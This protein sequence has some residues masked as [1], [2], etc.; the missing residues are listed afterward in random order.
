MASYFILAVLIAV[1]AAASYNKPNFVKDLPDNMQKSY[2]TIVRN[3]QLTKLQKDEQLQQWAQTNNL[4]DQY[5]A[6]TKKQQDNENFMSKNT[7][8]IISQLSSV[9]AQLEAI[10]SNK[11]LT[12]DQEEE[13]IDS[14]EEQYWQEVPVL[15]FIRKMWKKAMGMKV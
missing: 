10:L 13:A 11:N 5:T 7:T 15:L 4:S 14:L 8:Q 3:S 2:A 12:R 6:Y 9:Q 1:T